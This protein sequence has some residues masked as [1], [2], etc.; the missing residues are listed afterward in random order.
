LKNKK[1]GSTICTQ[2][3]HIMGS[4][5]QHK[6]RGFLLPDECDETARSLYRERANSLLLGVTLPDEAFRLFVRQKTELSKL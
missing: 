3:E 6:K 5:F 4:V 1:T 2:R